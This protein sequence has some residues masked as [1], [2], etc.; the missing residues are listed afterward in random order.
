LAFGQ[1]LSTDLFLMPFMPMT[2][3]AATTSH[4]L[5]AALAG[6][7][8][9]RA[10]LAIVGGLSAFLLFSDRLFFILFSLPYFIGLIASERSESQ[11]FFMSRY[12]SLLTFTYCTMNI[13]AVAREDPAYLVGPVFTIGAL[14]GRGPDVRQIIIPASH[15]LLHPMRIA[16]AFS[17]YVL[18]AWPS[19]CSAGSVSASWE[20]CNSWR[21]GAHFP[22]VRLRLFQR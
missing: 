18:K 11:Y 13:F 5:M 2:H 12:L 4:F 22:C 19:F 9:S 15:S 16:V 8:Q 1:R 3:G 10:N 20:C 17:R 21:G 6:R 7:S 14:A